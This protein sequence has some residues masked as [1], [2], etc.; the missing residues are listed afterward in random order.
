MISHQVQQQIQFQLEI[1]KVCLKCHQK[2]DKIWLC[3]RCKRAPYCSTACQKADWIHHKNTCIPENKPTTE[4]S[5]NKNLEITKKSDSYS[6]EKLNNKIPEEVTKLI[7]ILMK[8]THYD[9]RPAVLDIK[10]E[11][12]CLTITG[13]VV[14]TSICT[15]KPSTAA[16]RDSK[17][18]SVIGI[19]K[20][21]NFIKFDLDSDDAFW[22]KK[23]DLELV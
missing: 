17:W 22:F 12:N 13:N 15:K 4:K 16:L 8:K 23:N 10:F 1:N 14:Y 20:K 5:N 3:G 9:T 19:V 7:E 6:K 18:N 2:V 11:N 21:V